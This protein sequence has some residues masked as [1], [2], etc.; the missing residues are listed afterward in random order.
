MSRRSKRDHILKLVLSQ[1]Q[2]GISIKK[3]CLKHDIS[4]STFYHL[5]KKH[6]VKS[7]QQIRKNKGQGF[8]PIKLSSCTQ[9]SHLSSDFSS[10]LRVYFPSGIVIE[11]GGESAFLESLYT[12]SFAAGKIDGS[13]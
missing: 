2:S 5:R 4:L 1:P 7:T 8:I 12:K 6:A 10:T 11:C 9:G 13:H 3:Y